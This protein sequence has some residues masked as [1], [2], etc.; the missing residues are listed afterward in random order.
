M[1]RDIYKF[2]SGMFTG[3]AVEHAVIALYMSQGVLNQPNLFGREWGPGSGWLGAL[4]YTILSLWLGYL[5]WRPV[6]SPVK[7]STG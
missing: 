1:K 6:E 4:L 7:K 2:M 5:G 3:F